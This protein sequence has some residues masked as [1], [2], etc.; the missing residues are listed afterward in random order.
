MIKIANLLSIYYAKDYNKYFLE[1]F[2]E[3]CA[4]NTTFIPVSQV[5]KLRHRD[6][7][8]LVGSGARIG[9]LEGNLNSSGFSFF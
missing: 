5:R 9:T 4:V 2:T 1:T 7:T 8:H 6:I 3:T